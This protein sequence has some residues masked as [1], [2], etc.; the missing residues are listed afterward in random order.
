MMTPGGAG[1][2]SGTDG[3]RTRDHVAPPSCVVSITGRAVGRR[4]EPPR[5]HCS[6]DG[7]LI[8]MAL[9]F[10]SRADGDCTFQCAPPSVVATMAAG[11]TDA[12]E[13]VMIAQQCRAS[14]HDSVFAAGCP[15]LS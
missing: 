2:G 4:S 7:Q 5:K 14:V 15:L 9:M 13:V 1:C 12:A 11:S 8:A 10:A 6:A 3:S